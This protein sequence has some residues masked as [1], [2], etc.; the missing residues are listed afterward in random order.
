M[1]RRP[2]DLLARISK[3]LLT[4][5][6]DQR[7]VPLGTYEDGRKGQPLEITKKRRN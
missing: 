6:K 5:L 2:N 7:R 4:A 3:F 1:K